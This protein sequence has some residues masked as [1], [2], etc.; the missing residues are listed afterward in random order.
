MRPALVG[1]APQR[2]M[3]IRDLHGEHGDRFRDVAVR[4]GPRYPEPGAEQRLVL[5]LAEPD[6]HHQRLPEAR[7]RPGALT[8]AAGPT[9]G[10]Q[11]PR[12]VDHEFP[13][14]VEHGTILDQRGVLSGEADLGRPS[15][16]GTPRLCPAPSTM[17]GWSVSAC[18]R[19][20]TG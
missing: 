1:D 18:L 6:Q 2:R 9:L 19:S 5:A 20:S 10:G 12:E 8:G 3:Q 11:Q 17:D 15:S 13:G 4:G 7:Q 14:H 16:T